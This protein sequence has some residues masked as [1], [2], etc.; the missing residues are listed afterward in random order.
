MPIILVVFLALLVTS[1]SFAETDPELETITVTA[2]RIK[3]DRPV[4]PV[5]TRTTDT[6]P[7][8]GA[9]ALRSLPSLAISQAGSLGSL[10]EV[11]VRGS[12]AN[13]LM[14]LMDGVELADP[15]TDASF[16][17]AN[18]SLTGT[19][20]VELLAGAH[21]AIWGSDALAGVLNFITK[22]TER[23]RRLSLEGGAFDTRHGALQLAD[24]TESFHYNLAL[25]EFRTDGTNIATTGDEDDGFEQSS[26]RLSGGYRGEVWT[27]DALFHHLES[28]ADFDPTPYP[29]YQPRDGDRVSTHDESLGSLAATWHGSERI[30]QQ[31]RLSY[32]DTDNR[33]YTDGARTSTTAADRFKATLLTRLR[34]NERHAATLLLEHEKERFEQ[35]GA[36]SIFGDPNQDQSVRTNSIALEYL[37]TPVDDLSLA[38][39]ARRD[40]NSDFKDKESFRAAARYR[41]TGDIEIWANWGTGIK[42]PSFVE[43][44]GFTPDTFI[45]NPNLD[46][47]TNKHLSAGAVLQRGQWSL[48]ATAFRDR[49]EDEINGFYFDSAAGAL[50]SINEAGTSKRDGVELEATLA[51][52][53]GLLSLGASWLD[54]ANPDGT[55]EVRRPEWQAYGTFRHERGPFSAELSGYYVGSREDLDFSRFP[56]ERVRL[57][58]YLLLRAHLA[59]RIGA[60]LELALRGE[61]LLDESYQDQLGYASPGRAVYLQLAIDI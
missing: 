8:V 15:A 59:Y 52:P 53:A 19:T 25:S 32:F 34:A 49:L 57:G 45:G 42:N 51:I 16:N 61:N 29:L 9:D 4:L 56:A 10:T 2:H 24:R 50:T 6:G 23:R 39:S 60:H 26:Y 35:R 54:A 13:H 1:T 17:F 37:W 20:R 33:S 22:P 7:A 38:L 48:R 18:L 31:I 36:A 14:V 55:R 28:D 58:D 43:R 30:E 21:S 11:R 47:E 40:H 44:F 46:S 27:I 5:L 41:L 3:T 12:E